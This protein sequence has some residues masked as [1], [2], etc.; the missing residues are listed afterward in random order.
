VLADEIPQA[1]QW[2]EGMLLAPQHFQQSSMR[3]ELLTQY[4]ALL[5]AP[6]SWGVRRIT[7][8]EKRLPSGTVRVVDL[9]AVMPDGTVVWHKPRDGRELMI[10]LDMDAYPRTSGVMVYLVQPSREAGDG[11]GLERYEYAESAPVPDLN[12]G[13]DGI[14]MP[15]MR[16]KLAL[17]AGEVPPPKY[18]SMPIAEVRLDGEACTVTSFIPPTLAVEVKSPLGEICGEVAASVRAKAMFISEQVRSPSAVVDKPQLMENGSR[19]QSLVAGLPQL[20]A[21]LSTG[22]SHP[23]PL[24]LSLCGMAGNLCALGSGII[25]PQFSRYD[26]ANPRASFEEVTNFCIRMSTEGVP[27]TYNAYPFRRKDRAFSLTFDPSWAG[28][29]LILALRAG[30]GATQKEMVGWGDSCLIGTDVALLRDRRIRGAHRSFVEQYE[31]LVPSRGVA[32]YQLTM[33]EEFIRPG[34]LLQI[35]NFGEL[36]R[37]FSP[38]EIVLYVKRS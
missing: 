16:P 36:G 10:T 29:T 35:L 1:V 2:C 18:V 15:V 20:E 12:T 13:E 4:A 9:E 21:L 14:R 22:T 24:Y 38:I 37:V 28:R 7:L 27:Q 30:A 11:G 23:L 8:D 26:H 32:L 6:Y 33:D 19:M 5:V 17:M 34:K 31:E 25:P 3:Q